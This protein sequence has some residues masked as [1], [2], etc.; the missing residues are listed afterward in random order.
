MNVKLQSAAEFRPLKAVKRMPSLICAV[1]HQEHIFTP[2]VFEQFLTGVPTL[3]S[4][5]QNPST[6]DEHRVR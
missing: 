6:P 2:F 5:N 1:K 4:V 3:L